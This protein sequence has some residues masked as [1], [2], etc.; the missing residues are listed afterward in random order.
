MALL[1]I[2]CSLLGSTSLA[3]STPSGSYLVPLLLLGRLALR[4]ALQRARARG[5]L[6]QKV[7]IVGT[8]R[9]VDEV[10]SVLEARVVAG[11]DVVGA[12]TPGGRRRATTMGVPVLGGVGEVAAT[13]RR[14]R[15]CS[16]FAGGAVTSAAQLRH[17][18]GARALGLPGCGRA[19][20]HG[21][22][23]RTCACTA[24]GWTAPA[25]PGETA[26]SGCGAQ[27]EANFDLVGSFTLLLLLS[28]IL[29]VAAVQVWS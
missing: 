8:G 19:E 29:L 6:S 9:H 3:A 7:L 1:G 2:G 10:A 23:A 24:S 14:E 28:P 21:C 20:S 15:R 18:L 5:L 11:Y 12:L 27:G 16:V 13:A 17:T 4:L 26:H 22:V 25:P